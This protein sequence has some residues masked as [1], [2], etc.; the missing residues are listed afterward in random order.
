MPKVVSEQEVSVKENA[1]KVTDN[2]LKVSEKV[3]DEQPKVS[4]RGD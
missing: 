3:T 4:D 2:H 1:D